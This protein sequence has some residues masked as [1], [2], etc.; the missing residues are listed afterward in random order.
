MHV[1]IINF[2][3]KDV[4]EADY[5]GHCDEVAPAFAEVPGLIS[6]V[7]LANQTTK[8][9]G[10]VY[11]WASREAM[12]EYAKSDLF[13]AVATNPNLAGIT[14]IDFDVLE[15]PTSL[16]RGLAGAPAD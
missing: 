4:S 3:L 10:G 11:M 12:D 14:S 13:K 15:E 5:R 8:T 16:T 2:H 6:K 9:Y 1:Q 7:W